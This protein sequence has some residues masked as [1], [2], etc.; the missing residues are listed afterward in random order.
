MRTDRLIFG[1][2]FSLL[3]ATLFAAETDLRTWS[4]SGGGHTLKAEYLGKKGKDKAYLLKEDG[5]LVTVR[6]DALSE[7]DRAYIEEAENSDVDW[8][9]EGEPD[10]AY[11]KKARKNLAERLDEI[12]AW[13]DD[14]DFQNVGFD[15]AGP[16]FR[17]QLQ[18]KK[19]RKNLTRQPL[20]DDKKT[21]IGALADAAAH[22]LKLGDEYAESGGDVTAQSRK[23]SEYVR[24]VFDSLTDDPAEA[25]GGASASSRGGK[26]DEPNPFEEETTAP[27][28][29][30]KKPAGPKSRKPKVDGDDA[31]EGTEPS[32]RPAPRKRRDK[33]SGG[34]IPLLGTFT[35]PDEDGD[36]T[37]DEETG[38]VT[39]AQFKRVKMEMTKKE[40]FAILGKGTKVTV[41]FV[42]GFVDSMGEVYLWENDDDLGG[43]E[44]TFVDGKVEHKMWKGPGAEDDSGSG[45]E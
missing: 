36:E 21:N 3:A 38:K 23:E 42:G 40:V 6:L 4:S 29:K 34:L 39:Y 11:Y 27:P 1:V 26:S 19:V 9:D 13:K 33:N 7:D 43:C 20:G 5:R 17:W 18:V 24:G 8:T 44:I 35:E 15:P 32:E 30:T 22:L 14:E 41:P 37:A 10:K 25:F 12:E 45:G 16:F 2:L 31:E 28:K